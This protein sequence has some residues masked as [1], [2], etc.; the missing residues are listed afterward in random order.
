MRGHFGC[1]QFL[2]P[3]QLWPGRLLCQGG[4]P[5]KNTGGYWS[6]LI[7]I[8]FYSTIF[9]AAIAG[10]SCEYLILPE[11]LWPKQLHH[12]HTWPSLGQ[13]KS[14]GAASGTNPGDEPLAVVEIKPQLKP[15]SRVA[16]EADLKPSHQLYKLQIKSKWSTRETLCLWSI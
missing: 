2:C 7:A 3:F 11:P 13:T 9:P 15:R 5:G 6:I 1:V 10:N 4:S 16:K 12:L 8:P 14:S